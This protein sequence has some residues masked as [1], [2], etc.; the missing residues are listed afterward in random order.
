MKAGAPDIV[1]QAIERGFPAAGDLYCD[2]PP[3]TKPKLREYVPGLVVTGLA[4]L[5]AAYIAERYGAPLTMMA[6]LIGLALNFL[7]AD[8]RLDPGLALASRTLLRVSI[9]LL[10]T[11]VTLEQAGAL[12]PFSFAALLVIVV[13]TMLVG[14][15]LA[16]WLGSGSA[17]GALAG[18]AVA[19][20]GA[21]AALAIATLLGERRI[22]QAQLALVLVAI[23]GISALTMVLYPILAHEIG[24]H[25]MQAGFLLGASI[26]E[27]AHSLGAGYSFS[28]GA[29]EIATIVKMARVA[30]LAPALLII[31]LVLGRSGRAG[32]P[33]LPWFVIG[34]FMVAAMNSAGFIPAAV[35]T[36]AR[37]LATALLACAV[38][39]TGIRSPMHSLL[40]GGLRPLLVILAASA[41]ALGLSVA[42]AMVFA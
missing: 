20:C 29:G 5:A 17:F 13:I 10:G 2:V 35:G 37:D 36:A 6:L 39:A 12:G 9:V 26:H 16:R 38:A 33:G 23:S 31:G 34:F 7:S 25:D 4:T 1:A 18:G 11:R 19:I 28:P 41:A 3:P 40:A 15:L 21:S 42:A 24:L 32:S 30:L 22:N 27:V 14:L 8:R